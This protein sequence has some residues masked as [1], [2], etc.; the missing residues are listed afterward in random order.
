MAKYKKAKAVKMPKHPKMP[1]M[2]MGGLGKA[3]GVFLKDSAD[4][5][6]EEFDLTLVAGEAKEVTKEVG[7]AAKKAYPYLELLEG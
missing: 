6:F 1:K 2:P 3:S 5:Y 4:R 7:L